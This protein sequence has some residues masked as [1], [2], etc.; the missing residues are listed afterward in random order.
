MLTFNVNAYR[1]LTPRC[2]CILNNQILRIE[3]CI[4]RF[5]VTAQH[6]GLRNMVD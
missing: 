3:G 1:S 2:R 4:G 5:L 6:V